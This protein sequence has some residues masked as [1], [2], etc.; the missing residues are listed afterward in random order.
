MF[1]GALRRARRVAG[2]SPQ[3]VFGSLV[4][5]GFIV[6]GT[7]APLLAAYHYDDQ[8]LSSR[9]P[10]ARCGAVG[11]SRIPWGRTSSGATR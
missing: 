7:L 1:G 4:V 9:A 5:L 2:R 6:V 3:M 8:D 11:R 10:A